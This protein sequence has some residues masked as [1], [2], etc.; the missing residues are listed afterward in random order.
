MFS[1]HDY[2][3]HLPTLERLEI[4]GNLESCQHLTFDEPEEVKERIEE[5]E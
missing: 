4:D 3:H 1:L 2:I 5:L